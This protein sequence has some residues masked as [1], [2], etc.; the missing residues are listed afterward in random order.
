VTLGRTLA[1]GMLTPTGPP[2]EPPPVVGSWGADDWAVGTTKGV[3]GEEE[4]G[5]VQL[6]GVSLPE[7]PSTWGALRTKKNVG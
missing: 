3:E 6:P 2:A 1:W 4:P 5:T 7:P